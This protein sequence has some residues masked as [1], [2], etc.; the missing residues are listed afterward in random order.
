MIVI[1]SVKGITLKLKTM[2]NKDEVIKKL[3]IAIVDTE[4]LLNGEVENTDENLRS[5]I[6]ILQEAK[7]M[8]KELL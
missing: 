1:P 4:M 2:K 7:K 3:S 6:E 8:V 5:T